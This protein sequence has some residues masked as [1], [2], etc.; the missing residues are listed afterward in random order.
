M[1]RIDKLAK[2]P[3]CRSVQVGENDQKGQTRQT[4]Q[5]RQNGKNGR[6]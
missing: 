3:N 6:A 4:R 2:K 1:A 5:N